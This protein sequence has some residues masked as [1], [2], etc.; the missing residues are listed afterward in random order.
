M[1]THRF[2]A[3]VLPGVEM[4]EE[5][6]INLISKTFGLKTDEWVTVR[7]RSP[8][9]FIPRQLLMTCL[10]DFLLYTQAEAGAVCMRD[11][12]TAFNSWKK[13]HETFMKDREYGEK[14]SHVY[15]HCE[16]LK[17]AIV[18]KKKLGGFAVMDYCI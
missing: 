15:N 12:A 11:H 17:S 8:L 6:I 13:I 2:N 5:A 16:L 14:V 10:M 18:R 7:C 1:E 3:Y 4:T 9:Y